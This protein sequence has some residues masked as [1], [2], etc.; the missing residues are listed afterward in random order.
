[1]MHDDVGT[2][3]GLS[4]QTQPQSDFSSKTQC[5]AT[6]CDNVTMMYNNFEGQIYLFLHLNAPP[7]DDV[8]CTHTPGGL[9]NAQRPL[10]AWASS[11]RTPPLLPE[12]R[13]REMV[14]SRAP[15]TSLLFAVHGSSMN[16]NTLC[17]STNIK[18]RRA[19]TDDSFI[20]QFIK[21]ASRCFALLC[22]KCDDSIPQRL[23]H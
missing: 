6:I 8:T 9:P 16:A 3:T 7:H 1:M 14:S 13:K 22:L 18:R 20:N 21:N 23:M 15:M 5:W 17:P 2:R 11:S 12:E 10:S 19:V 4:H